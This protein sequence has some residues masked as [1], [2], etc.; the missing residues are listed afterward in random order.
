MSPG[1]K[2]FYLQEMC[3]EYWRGSGA[4]KTLCK[5]EKATG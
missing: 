2:K 4:G 3:K 5:V 1:L